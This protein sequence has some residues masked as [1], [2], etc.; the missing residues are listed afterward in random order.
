MMKFMALTC[1]LTSTLPY[2]TLPY[3][4]EFHVV[5]GVP[6]QARARHATNLPL[7]P[8]LLYPYLPTLL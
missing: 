5:C 1:I 2:P 3:F 8:S 4:E 7:P 6:L